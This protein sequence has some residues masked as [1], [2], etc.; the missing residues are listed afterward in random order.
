MRAMVLHGDGLA[1][2]EIDRPALGPLQVL[3]RVR[4]CGI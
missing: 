3:S 1:V 2:E 4:A